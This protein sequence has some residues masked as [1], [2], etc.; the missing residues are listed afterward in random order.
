VDETALIQRPAVVATSSDTGVRQAFAFVKKVLQEIYRAHDWESLIKEQTFVTDGSGSYAFNAIV[1]DNDYGRTKN[2]TEW[3]RSNNR[4]LYIVTAEEWQELVSSTVGI[5][6]IRRFARA[7]GGNFIIENDASGDTLVFEYVSNYLVNDSAGN[8]KLTY[9]E[10]T[11]VAILDEELI[12]LGLKAY[13]KNEL[14]LDAQE[15]FDAYYYALAELIGQEKPAKKIRGTSSFRSNY[16]VNI[17]DTGV[18]Q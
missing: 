13:W 4:K 18:G 3:D 6:G 9:T 14:G 5:V 11:D 1:T 8:S 10:D 17:P 15:D 7:R 16:I 12:E 2:Q